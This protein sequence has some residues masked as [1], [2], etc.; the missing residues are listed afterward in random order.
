MQRPRRFRFTLGLIVGGLGGFAAGAATF[1]DVASYF[2]GTAKELANEIGRGIATDA[3]WRKIEGCA[4]SG[5]RAEA[6]ERTYVAFRA[7]RIMLTLRDKNGPERIITFS[8]N[9][10]EANGDFKKRIGDMAKAFCKTGTTPQ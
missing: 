3:R 2:R 10:F 6:S 4:E 7:R 8:P 9:L 1:H 5:R